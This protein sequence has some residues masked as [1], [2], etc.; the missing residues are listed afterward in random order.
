MNGSFTSKDLMTMYPFP[1]PQCIYSKEYVKYFS[2]QI[3]Q[4]RKDPNKHKIEEFGKYS[5]DSLTGPLSQVA[6]ILCRFHAQPNVSI[7][8]NNWVPLRL[9]ISL[10]YYSVR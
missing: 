7:L 8:P 2:E 6:A 9:Y 5:I 1:N 3:R 10:G 4:W